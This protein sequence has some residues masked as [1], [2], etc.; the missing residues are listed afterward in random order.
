MRLIHLLIIIPIALLVHSNA[1]A[2]VCGVSTEIFS[3]D[4][5]TGG[6]RT[7]DKIAN[8]V[9]STSNPRDG[10]YTV[11]DPSQF[12]ANYVG[13]GNLRDHTEGDVEGSVL[14]INMVNAPVIFYR[15]MVTGVAPNLDLSFQAW[16]NGTCPN[17]PDKGQVEFIINDLNGNL[18]AQSGSGDAVLNDQQ[19]YKRNFTFN[20]GANTDFEIILRNDA[21]S[22]AN[23]NDIFVDDIALCQVSLD[24][25]DAPSTGT[26]YGTPQHI[27]VNDV[28][29]GN[30]V[31]S[32]STPYDDANAAGDVDDGIILPVLTQGLTATIPV[33]VNQVAANDGYLQAWIDWDGDGDFTEA[34]DQIASNL[35]SSVAGS[36]T[37]NITVTPPMTAALSQTFARFRWSTN[38]D[39]GSNSSAIN[40]EI[41]DYA[42]TI[43]KNPFPT[44]LSVA[45]CSAASPSTAFWETRVGWS[46]QDGP[47][48][49][50][51][52]N[53]DSTFIARA[54]PYTFGDGI[55][56]VNANTRS[57][58]TG[59]DQ[60]NFSD[61]YMD[62]DYLEYTIQTQT[63]IGDT[64]V[65][66][67]FAENG[68][69]LNGDAFKMDLLASDDNFDTAVRLNTGFVVD[70]NIDPDSGT[71]FSFIREVLTEMY[72]K[73]NTEYKIRA[74]LY[75]ATQVGGKVSMDDFRISFNHC[76]DF[77]DA[78][79]S[80][81]AGKHYLTETRSHF[82]GT[83]SPD[84]EMGPSSDDNTAGDATTDEESGVVIPL[85]SQG[86]TATIQVPVNGAG[87]KLSAW[88]DWNGDQTFDASERIATNVGL[89]G[90]AASGTISLTV[91]VPTDATT[92][93][94]Y[95]RFRWSPTDLVSPT[96][97]VIG[98]EI[99]D[100]PVTITAPILSC[101]APTS[102]EYQLSGSA[103][104]GADDQ[105]VLTDD[106]EV[107]PSLPVQ[108]YRGQSGSMWSKQRI[109]LLEPFTFAYKVYLGSR[110]YNVHPST[111]DVA[112]ADG[113]AFGLHN[114]PA[115][116]N[117][118]GSTGPGL[119][120]GGLDPAIAIE[121]DTWTGNGASVNDSGNS[122]DP[123]HTSIFDPAG[124]GPS[125][126]LS[127]V[128]SLGEIEDGQYHDVEVSWDPVTQNLV[129]SFDGI[130]RAN[131]TRDL[132]NLDFNGD[133]FVF[134]GVSAST[135]GGYNL[136]QV[137]F[138]SVPPIQEVDYG[139]AP[140]Y[141]DATHLL[142][143]GVHLGALIDSETNSQDSGL[144]A[145]GDDT[146]GS[147]DD[148]G[149]MFDLLGAERTLRIDMTNQ[150][151]VTASTSGFLNAWIDWNQDGDWDDAGEQIA[152]N[153]PL[154]TGTN[155]LNVA[156]GATAL[157]GRTYA[158]FRF[159]STSVTA[160]S[161]LGLLSDGE[162]EDY[163]LTLEY[164]GEP[165]SCP[166]TFF[167]IIDTQ[168]KQLNVATGDYANVGSAVP[169]HYNA[170]GYNPVDDFI[171][172]IL[173]EPGST[174]HANLVVVN[175]GG[176]VTD[177]G[178][179]N[180]L[181]TGFPALGT[182]NNGEFDS[183]GNLWVHFNQRMYRIDVE[184]R[185][186][187]SF[188]VDA[189][190]PNLSDL[191]FIDDVLYGA[192]ND[193]L[194]LIDISNTAPSITLSV[195]NKTVINLA[196]G[197]YGAGYRDAGGNLF[198]SNN[199]G[200]IYQILDY[201][202]ATPTAAKI[203]DTIPTN[204]NDGMSC[205]SAGS[206]FN[207]DF[208]DAPT[209]GTAPDGVNAVA[210]GITS[211]NYVSGVKLGAVLDIDSAS[212]ADAT[213][214]ATGDGADDD[215]VALPALI[216]GMAATIAVEVSGAGGYLQGWID[217]NGDGDFAD[218]G[219]QVATDLQD[220]GS[221][222]INILVDVPLNATTN[223]T[224]AR[225]RWSTT[226]SLNAV[227][228]AADGEVEDYALT[229]ETRYQ[230][231]LPSGSCHGTY[232]YWSVNANS[233]PLYTAG[234]G[235]DD[236][237][238]NTNA[239]LIG[240]WQP[241][242]DGTW[243]R[244][245]SPVP[246]GTGTILPHSNAG[247]L[248]SE[249]NTPIVESVLAVF[250]MTAEPN[251]PYTVPLRDDGSHE[252]QTIAAF[253][254][255]GNLISPTPV[256][257]D[258]SV[259]T[260]NY[261]LLVDVPAS[262]EFFIYVWKV[263]IDQS[264]STVYPICAM[265]FGDAPNSYGDASHVI[266][267]SVFL[268]VLID[269]DAASQNTGLLADG[270]DTD[271][272]N[273]DDG[274][275]F[276]L[277]N[278]NR[279]L[280]LDSMNLYAVDTS[281]DGFLNAWIDWNQDG[282]WDDVGEQ[283][284]TNEPMV[285]G[286]NLLSVSVS[287]TLALGTTFARFRFTSASVNTP[288]PLGLMHDGE[289]EDY[290][291]TLVRYPSVS[292]RVYIDANSNAIND[293]GETG[294]AG[295]VVVLRDVATGVCNSTT[296]SGSGDYA[297]LGVSNGDYEIYQAHGETTPIPQS[298]GVAS[299]VN[300]AGYQSTTPDTLNVTVSD[301]N[302]TRQDF[303][304]V[305]G[306][307]GQPGNALSPD[308]QGVITAGS[309]VSYAHVYTTTADG[310]VTFDTSGSLNITNGWL[311]RLYQ[312]TNCDGVLNGTEARSTINGISLN[313][314]AGGQVCLINRVFAPS[315]VTSQEQYLSEVT[316]AFDYAGGTLPSGTLTATDLTVVALNDGGTLVLE[317]SVANLNQGGAYT[318]TV[319]QANLGDEL[320]Y[321][322]IYSNPG[323]GPVTDV[324][325][326]DEVPAF[327]SY[328]SG[329]AVCDSTPATMVCTPSVN[330]SAVEW[331]ITGQLPA[332]ASGEVS[333]KILIDN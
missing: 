98:G 329:S 217:W 20:A 81:N 46:S 154:V 27:V 33:V 129:Y 16:L 159:T 82:I 100:Y 180:N 312:D 218:A 39:L 302:V 181:S 257:T 6:P 14:A 15:N 224:F 29:L 53:I 70:S 323:T 332:G 5:G 164:K 120:V 23:G 202:T 212:I 92:S 124:S 185:E 309:N 230:P 48:G 114:D 41:E 177:L 271:G 165:F 153:E 290:A 140:S 253:D 93:T 315:N 311:A 274:V 308:N 316:A 296:T 139:D 143:T 156:V 307:N 54:D 168:L 102:D 209:V 216:Q 55:F 301:A 221:G 279:T 152:T 141:G 324:T 254:A 4:F 51:P 227:D 65:I 333:F 325:I 201:D 267:S 247:D 119:G 215:G 137:C 232:A 13:A 193:T 160:P 108:A 74:V 243:V 205:P 34:S 241:A 171:Y 244:A 242:S 128:L 115:G 219:E 292:G 132:I 22:G 280:W 77:G 40:G 145:D 75:D 61:A 76:S 35:Q 287:P 130:E 85:L 313:V 249:D 298:C 125:A 89:A 255:A 56:A 7:Y 291:I 133:P 68:G 229:I 83:V 306:G 260:S 113:L 187:V 8:H 97:D 235:E 2:Q 161:P 94:T 138:E 194:Y 127:P 64:V 60:S 84:A 188:A 182:A 3:D 189:N 62:G 197:A 150:Y 32:E 134:Y 73:P 186:Y 157:R 262:G 146:D 208:S 57:E 67:G 196:N 265:D 288:S 31:T 330:G 30:G 277:L 228:S 170:S 275:T 63:T 72:V 103:F 293:S 105:V 52:S 99:E 204:K 121:F 297:F 59:V 116:Y 18:L 50:Y 149:V 246:D 176:E 252:E 233:N 264:S 12:T 223:Q 1:V 200:A 88:V 286:N 192:Y 248:I 258:S 245:D 263:D 144:L 190:I 222:T 11:E 211:H 225:F 45:K 69:R 251:Q 272:S 112:G 314:S 155:A 90:A 207:F 71:Q 162:V 142:V 104:I 321:R 213:T 269:N 259:A 101:I 131:I 43:E 175:E 25:S 300:P 173:F 66:A 9:Y 184:A 37:I 110:T 28:Y 281:V 256:T 278:G 289:V 166:S 17:C 284:A 151:E 266:T 206:P 326:N 58:I 294:I 19:W 231:T 199:N 328:Q 239:M 220:A 118:V 319:N 96:D 24:H 285:T 276:E 261:S 322:V 327:T 10:Q 250:R 87:G 174:R 26:N 237:Y 268:G 169:Y 21:A 78:P 158:R 135:G 163:A 198:L 49:F 304:E 86:A 123:D 107:I 236:N 331:V 270:D 167:Q 191:V 47:N 240:G 80:A 179:L 147:N 126:L 111:T 172:G 36:S 317:K 226:P 282:D 109:S 273:D 295:T 79:Y 318:N 210:Y 234:N 38:S 91:L 117:A 178:A 303:G 299:M 320:R 136:Q 106:D 203:I 95:A 238:S 195:T 305:R 42:L 283:I 214:N 183:S 122:F 310:T 148:D 44:E